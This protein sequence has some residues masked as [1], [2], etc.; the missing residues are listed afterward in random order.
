MSFHNFIITQFR[1]IWHLKEFL[2]PLQTLILLLYHLRM[3]RKRASILLTLLGIHKYP[4]SFLLPFPSRIHNILRIPLLNLINQRQFLRLLYSHRCSLGDRLI[5]QIL[6][7]S[8]Y[9][10]SLHLCLQKPV[11]THDL[12]LRSMR[13]VCLR[14]RFLRPW[15]YEFWQEL[16]HSV[17]L[18]WF[19]TFPFLG[20]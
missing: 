4:L 6:K 7:S 8:V 14:A 19:F 5:R 13:S 16:V 9:F 1:S 15:G 18:H 20:F 10:S 3:I 12:Y 11:L 2:R 17:F